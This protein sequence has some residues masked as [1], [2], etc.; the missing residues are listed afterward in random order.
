MQDVIDITNKFNRVEQEIQT[1]RQKCLMEEG[2]LFF[3]NWKWS[4][5]ELLESE[6]SGPQ[7]LDTKKG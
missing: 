4:I 3:K 6:Y 5:D 2:W 7:K 1:L